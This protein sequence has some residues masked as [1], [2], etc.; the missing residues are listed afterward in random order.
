MFKTMSGLVTIGLFTAT[1]HGAAANLEQIQAVGE[2]K[3][4]E[5]EKSQEKI[6]TIVEGAQ[7][8]LLKYRN[9]LKQI[10]GLESY[11]AQL[12]TQIKSQ[13]RL[14]ENFDRS[15]ARV[16]LIERQMLPLVSRMA[17]SLSQFVNLDLPFHTAERQERLA[18]IQDNLLAADIDIAEKFRQV[19]EAYRIESE[20]GRKIDT[21]QSIVTLEGAQREVDILRVGRIAMVCQTKDTT[22]SARW[23]HE[24]Q[25]WEI[26]DNLTY[27]NAVRQGIKMA[28]K[29]ASIDLLTLPIVAPEMAQ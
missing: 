25:T 19:I 23:D 10:E 22:R 11:N 21:Y 8:R 17:E 4:V 1:L 16:A 27:R 3:L 2:E 6:N 29:Q 9:L 15:I 7:D 13:Q 24:T 12:M 26:L 20:Y 18:L 14:V 28:K 5:A